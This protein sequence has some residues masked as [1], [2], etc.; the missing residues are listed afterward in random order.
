MAWV[1]KSR[2]E[3]DLVRMEPDFNL[4]H[5]QIAYQEKKKMELSRVPEPRSI[6]E[7]LTDSKDHHGSPGGKGREIRD[8]LQMMEKIQKIAGTKPLGE[9]ATMEDWEDTR[10]AE[11]EAV[12]MMRN[13]G[14]MSMSQ[15]SLPYLPEISIPEIK[16]EESQRLFLITDPEFF[17]PR[18]TRKPKDLE[19]ADHSSKDSADDSFH[20]AESSS[21]CIWL[22][23]PGKSQVSRASEKQNQ[24]RKREK[25][26]TLFSYIQAIPVEAIPVKGKRKNQRPS[27]KER[28][29]LQ[30]QTNQ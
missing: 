18:K 30:Q 21:S 14:M 4:I 22:Y 1:P 6:S 24:E 16:Q 29:R 13:F 2:F 3:H 11:Q 27:Q 20:T 23:G 9:H 17:T 19:P 28:R 10:T 26:D 25:S 12:A 5:G 8:C 7:Y 15:E